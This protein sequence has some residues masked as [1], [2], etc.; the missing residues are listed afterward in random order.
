MDIINKEDMA[1][2]RK[3]VVK[4]IDLTINELS[5]CLRAAEE[6]KKQFDAGDESFDFEK[7]RDELNTLSDH[8][9]GYWRR[10]SLGAKDGAA[11]IENYI[12]N[13]ENPYEE[14]SEIQTGGAQQ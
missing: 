14:E 11:I 5:E 2:E 8:T 13:V 9:E 1:D 4:A 6:I 10:L 3:S 12:A 7:L